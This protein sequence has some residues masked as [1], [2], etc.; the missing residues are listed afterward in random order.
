VYFGPKKDLLLA[1]TL[2][3]LEILMGKTYDDRVGA[4]GEV[5]HIAFVPTIRVYPWDGP[6]PDLENSQVA[7]PDS[8]RVMH[9]ALGSFRGIQMFTIVKQ[10][11]AKF[12]VSYDQRLQ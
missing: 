8:T 11:I 6:R 10:Q 7:A 2:T 4:I 1:P 5:Q 9:W 3:S 12:F